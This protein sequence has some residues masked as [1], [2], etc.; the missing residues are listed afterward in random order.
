MSGD[1][2]YTWLDRLYTSLAPESVLEIGVGEGASLAHVRPPAIAI[3]VDPNPKA[4]FPLKVNTHLFTETSDEFFARRRPDALLA[5][6]PLGI[7]F[8]DG[9]PLY[10]QALKDFINLERYCG[11]RSVVLFHDTIPLDEPT[12]S[13][14]HNTQFHTGDVWKTVLCLKRYRPD[15]NIFTIATPWTGLTVVTG[16]DPTDCVLADGYDAAVAQFIDMSFSEI[17]NRLDAALNIVPND[18]NVVEARL[19]AHNLL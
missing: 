3:G 11:P 17:E 6:R 4:A 2:Y 9:L 12:Q 15:L 7:G 13:R 5:G 14:A 10:E 16:L 1:F 8:I 19:K 18:W